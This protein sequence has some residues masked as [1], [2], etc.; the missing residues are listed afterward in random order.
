MANQLPQYDQ[1]QWNSYEIMQVYTQELAKAYANYAS[2]ISVVKQ[3][4]DAYWSSPH[5][6]SKA[7]SYQIALMNTELIRTV[8][9][10]I[11]DAIKQSA[12]NEWL[13]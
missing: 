13:P 11:K 6:K 1:E 7:M 2:S 12:M 4:H 9:Q 8:V 10:E 3:A 5:V